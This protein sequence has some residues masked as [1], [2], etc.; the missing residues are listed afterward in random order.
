M[1]L[2]QVCLAMITTL[3][4][5][6]CG[7]G[8]SSDS[9]N[10]AAPKVSASAANGIYVGNVRDVYSQHGDSIVFPLVAVV[11]EGEVYSLA[12]HGYTYTSSIDVQSN[13]DYEGTFRVYD[14]FGDFLQTIEVDGS[15]QEKT[16]LSGQYQSERG[17]DSSFSLDY[18]P[19][20]YEVPAG[21]DMIDGVWSVTNSTSNASITINSNGEFFGS[22]DAG[23]VFSGD[24]TVPNA[25]VNVYRVNLTQ[26]NCG[27]INGSYSGLASL[28]TFG[29]SPELVTIVSNNDFSFPY[30]LREQ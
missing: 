18:V 12:D 19:E 14:D 25:S 15:Y 10:S 23:C 1:E 13:S 11:Y 28:D 22:D 7:G 4:L 8:G 5:S 2:K 3:A 16:S 30:L 21:L 24:I 29:P 17:F 26:E 27:E 9:G 6:A 20:A